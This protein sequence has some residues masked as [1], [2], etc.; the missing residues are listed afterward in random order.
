MWIMTT[1]GFVSVVA[2]GG[3]D[4]LMVRSREKK[5]IKAFCLGA[6][7]PFS[8]IVTG[9]GTDY[10]HRVRSNK[11]EVKKFL[12]EEVD[13]IDYSNFKDRAKSNSGNVF[14]GFLSKVWSA[15]LDLEDIDKKGKWRSYRLPFEKANSEYDWTEEI[16]QDLLTVKNKL[17]YGQG[18]LFKKK[19]KKKGTKS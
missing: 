16:D 7:R 14:A 13:Y 18:T 19:G 1:E 15:S 6:G 11:D 3:K 12:L 4:V 9:T 2:K 8:D 10:P 17:G 5:A